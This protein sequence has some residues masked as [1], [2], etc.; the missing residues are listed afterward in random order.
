VTDEDGLITAVYDYY[1]YGD[2][3]I[4]DEMGAEIN[5]RF[6]GQ[7]LDE[8]TDLHYYGARYYSASLGKFSTIDPLAFYISNSKQIKDK[9][10]KEQIDILSDPQLLNN[11]SYSRN[12]PVVYVDP[13][14]NEPISLTIT[15]AGITIGAIITATTVV[16]TYELISGIKE[17][18]SQA[19]VSAYEAIKTIISTIIFA[20]SQKDILDKINE[21]DKPI[22]KHI[23]K[24]KNPNE[25]GGDD[26]NIRNKWRKEID[27][28]I[29]RQKDLADKLKSK[30]VKDKALEKIQEFTNEFEIIPLPST[31]EKPEKIIESNIP[32]SL[33]Y[34]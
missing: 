6:T 10:N 15:A 3:R 32:P 9:L 4:A 25:P 7:E 5:N 19:I 30:A 17:T 22:Q 2:N 11:Y 23:D 27:R 28:F 26:P 18:I 24:L 8:E 1:P 33:Q 13:N 31:G 14:G 16:I 20:R 21:L 34:L 29:K 12:N